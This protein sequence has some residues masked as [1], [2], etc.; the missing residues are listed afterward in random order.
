MELTKKN[1]KKILCI[2]TFAIAVYGLVQNYLVVISVSKYLLG[3]LYPFILGGCLA[4][5]LNVPMR[6]LETRIIKPLFKNRKPKFQKLVRPISLVLTLLLLIA[7]IILV[8]FII[9][10]EIGR[11]FTTITNSIPSFLVKV[12]TWAIGLLDSYPAIAQ[13]IMSINLDTKE[14]LQN[15]LS[16]IQSAGGSFLSSTIGVAT[17][18]ASGLFSFFLAFVFA[19]YVVAQKE[20]LSAQIKKFL[21]AFVPEKATTKIIRISQ[22]A[23]QTFSRFLSGQCVEAAILGTMFFASMLILGFPYPLM[24]GVLIGVTALIPMFGAFIGLTIGAFLLLIISPVR[25]F[26]F[27]ILSIILQQIEGDFIYPHVVGNSVGLP[28]IWVLVAVTIGGSAMGITGMLIFIPIASVA[29]ALLREETHKRLQ[30]K[31]IQ[32]Q[33]VTHEK[34]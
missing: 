20:K 29:Y 1:V 13:K 30:N 3:M 10:P 21:F 32:I 12:R 28:S 8:T 23:E 15:A 26:W 33:E 27:I 19:I 22:M 7:L 34:A 9:V 4:F 17:G 24:I 16:I 5:I 11:A 14:L 2:I 6:A 18:V 25:A 31:S